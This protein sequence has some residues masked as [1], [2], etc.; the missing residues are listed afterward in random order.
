MKGLGFAHIG[1]LFDTQKTSVPKFAPDMM[2]DKDIRFISRTFPLWVAL[3][4]LLPPLIGGLWSWSWQ[5]AV[6]A[7]FWGSLVRMA[8]MH[9]VTWS[10]NSVCHTFGRDDFKTADKS[11]NVYWLAIL[12]FGES[13]H[14]LHHSDPTCAR[15]GVLKRQ[16]DISARIIWLAEKLGWAYNVR[17]PDPKRIDN[18]RQPANRRPLGHM[19]WLV[20]SRNRAA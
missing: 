13:W 15:H 11:R 6:A 14:N 3:S 16:I 10:I 12:S 1:W 20:P 8:L 18:K 5:G 2:R 19:A 17:W 7:F 9:H 4:L